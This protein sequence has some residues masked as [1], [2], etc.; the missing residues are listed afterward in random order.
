MNKRISMV[1]AAAIAA[2]SFSATAQMS[3]DTAKHI[4]TMEALKS[5]SDAMGKMAD[6]LKV[7][8]ERSG[9]SQPQPVI[10]Q[11]PPAKECS[12]WGDCTVAFGK[13]LLGGVREVV[14]AVSP[15]AA[16]YY[17]YRTAGLQYD[18]QKIQAAETT[19]QIDARERTTQTMSGDARQ[20]AVAAVTAPRPP[21]T[22]IQ[23]TGNSG[24][25]NVGTGTQDNSNRPITTTT[26]PTPR[27]CSTSATGVLTCVGG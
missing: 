26:N 13:G 24:A 17:G 19:K 20:I 16:P 6:A 22:E 21:T 10:V 11:A 9:N 27:V 4:A 12:G 3:E 2:V 15:L 5:Q 18:F 23:V 25:V 1:L 8:T 7:A 14:Q